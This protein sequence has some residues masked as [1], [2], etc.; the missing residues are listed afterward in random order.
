[1]NLIVVTVTRLILSG[2]AFIL[3]FWLLLLTFLWLYWYRVYGATG[4]TGKQI[5]KYMKKNKSCGNLKWA[6]A[7]RSEDKLNKVKSEL[8]LG[9]IPILVADTS[10]DEAL[11]TVFGQTRL[12]LNCTGPYRFLGEPVVKACIESKTHYMVRELLS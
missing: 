6:I 1:M 12:V 2:L 3:S 7:G 11:R 8:D 9:D 4:F 5:V 10:N